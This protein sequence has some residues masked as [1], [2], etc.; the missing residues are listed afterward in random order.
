MKKG[1]RKVIMQ[2]RGDMDLLFCV[3]RVS[4][5]T[6]LLLIVI[7]LVI[8]LCK[9]AESNEDQSKDQVTLRFLYKDLSIKEAES[10][11]NFYVWRKDTWGFFG[12]S[13]IK[14]DYEAKSVKGDKIVIDHATGLMWH[15]SGAKNDMSWNKANQWVVDL[16]S[17]EYAG[18]NDWRLP[19]V[20][21]AASLLESETK[22]GILNIDPAFY[23][24]QAWI[25]T[26]D[27]YG[28]DKAWV[29][30]FKRWHVAWHFN[31]IDTYVRP[32]RTEK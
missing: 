25:W 30:H 21:E 16:N 26:G 15:Q 31:V 4:Y 23:S 11:P 22:N 24:I 19:T 1:K 28:P 8:G 12:Y 3:G 5:P 14:H 10:I 17:R 9:P 6:S 32:V 2:S 20:E 13:T 18:Y 7:L 27:R 29:V